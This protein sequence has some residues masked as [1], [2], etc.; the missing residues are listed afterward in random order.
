MSL[1]FRFGVNLIGAEDPTSFLGAARRAEELGFDVLQVPDHLGMPAPFP[2]LVAAAGVTQRI[3][4]GTFVLSAAFYRPAVLARDVAA[5]DQFVGGRLELGLGAGYVKGE[6]DAAGVDYG[7][8]GARLDHLTAT[9]E[10]LR[11]RLSDPEHRP[12][13]AQAR[14]PLLLGGSGPRT[15]RLAARYADTVGFTGATADAVGTLSLLDAH[16]LADRVGVVREAAGGRAPELNVLVQQVLVDDTP[17]DQVARRVHE[18]A[19]N[20]SPEQL[21]A[22]REL[23]ST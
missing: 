14:I 19:P 20:L 23:E 5:T 2:S 15:L 3:R 1:P 16:T 7:T 11:A 9:I 8:A 17:R 13:P 6:F 10:E 12:A 18:Y 21:S 4:L 22:V